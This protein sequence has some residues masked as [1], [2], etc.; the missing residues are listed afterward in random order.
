MSN[1]KV[2]RRE[3]SQTTVDNVGFENIIIQESTEL[4]NCVRFIFRINILLQNAFELEI[5]GTICSELH[6]LLMHYITC[7]LSR[8]S[9]KDKILSL[10]CWQPRFLRI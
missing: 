3:F 6:L 1:H 8:D 5:R 4:T 2:L 7:F 9:S 10:Y